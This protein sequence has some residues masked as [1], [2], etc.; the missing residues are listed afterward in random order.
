MI[1]REEALKILEE[2]VQN[3]NIIKHMLATEAMMKALAKKFE[4]EK[5]E[6]WGL[7]GLLHDGDYS[8]SVPLEKQ[9]IQISEWVE[10][11]GYDVPE[12]VK[13]AMAAHNM[14]NTGV[15]P[16]SKM[17]WA[18]FC[19][20]SLTG[21]IVA[22][23]LVLPDKKLAGVTSETVLKRFKEPKFA[24]GTRREGIKMCE[25]HLGISLEEFVKI[26]LEAMQ[27]V[28]EEIGL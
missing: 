26:T 13:H 17:D 27:E 1:N 22:S 19:G 4:P 23:A 14:E 21:L 15:K 20:D 9:G 28:H 16:E 11:K 6:E 2:K 8:E 18:L 7:S 12:A 10:E 24:A 3:Q 25:E 5:I